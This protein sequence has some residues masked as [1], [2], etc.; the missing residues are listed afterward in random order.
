MAVHSEPE[1][2]PRRPRA[3]FRRYWA[4][5]LV[6][7]LACLS[8]MAFLHNRGPS[9]EAQSVVR[10]RLGSDVLGLIEAHLTGRTALIATAGR[11]DITGDSAPVT[12]REAIGLHPLTPVAGTT[13]GLPPDVAGIVISVRLPDADQ[14]AQVANDL[15]LQV[16]DLGQTGQLDANHDLLSFYGNEEQ[17]LWQEIA[18]L[19]A[20]MSGV[21]VRTERDSSSNDRPLVLLQDQYEVVRHH[22]AEEE[23][24]TRLAARQRSADFALLQR[25][26]VGLAVRSGNIWLLGTLAGAVLLSLA[27]AFVAERGS[28]ASA[29]LGGQMRDGYRL[30]DD[31]SRPIFGLPRFVVVS[32]VLVVAMILAS[33]L[34]R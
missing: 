7:V 19:K 29:R 25:A 14:A 18:A 10:V 17:R 33:W 21:R 16:L 8:A 32:A 11:H 3:V 5:G 22:L 13:L 15:A 2:L 23:V 30:V 28:W 6:I 20:E 34:I 31:P 24:A 4:V 26:S 12:L 1:A 27:A 9:Y